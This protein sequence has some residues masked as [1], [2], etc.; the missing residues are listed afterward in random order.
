MRHPKTIRPQIHV[1]HRS[2]ILFV[3]KWMGCKYTG[4]TPWVSLPVGT[5]DEPVVPAG[6]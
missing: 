6:E 1:M 3:N 2:R 5:V 4:L